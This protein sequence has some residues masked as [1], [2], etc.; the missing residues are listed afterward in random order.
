MKD[1]RVVAQGEPRTVLTPELLVDVYGVDAEIL[2]HGGV[3]VVAPVA[4]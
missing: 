4:S 1:G 2:D 3:P